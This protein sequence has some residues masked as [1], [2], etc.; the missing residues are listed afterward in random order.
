MSLIT[1]GDAHNTSTV[2]LLKLFFKVTIFGQS[3]GAQS[4]AVH[5]VNDVSESLFQRAIL[6]SNPFGLSFKTT[7][8][9]QKLGDN[10]VNFMNG[11]GE[12]CE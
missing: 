8:E 7:D 5:L 1:I 10:F 9:A 6:Q 4:V 12:D 3:A 11:E 2:R